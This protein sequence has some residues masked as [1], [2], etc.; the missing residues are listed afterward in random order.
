MGNYDAVVKDYITNLRLADLIIGAAKGIITHLNPSR[1][2]EHGCNVVFDK[3][4]ARL[5]LN[6][7]GYVKRKGTKAARK[8]P[9]DFDAIKAA[10]LDH[11]Q[12]AAT[13]ES[14]LVPPQLIVNLDQ[15][16]AKFVPVS[17]WTLAP[18]GSKQVAIIAKDDKREMTVLL[19][20]SLSG[21]L[22]PPSPRVKI[23]GLRKPL[24]WNIWSMF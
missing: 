18:Q 21:E 16:G 23:I 9:P 24:C 14:S 11:V 17:E 13:V 19:S 8:L 7:V 1:L 22:L 3:S 6:R 4:W 10:F 20:C 12:E 5:F 15:T 2:Q